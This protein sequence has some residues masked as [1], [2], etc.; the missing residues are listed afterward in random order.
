MMY[1]VLITRFLVK[2]PSYTSVISSFSFLFWVI[3]VAVLYCLV[4]FPFILFLFC[5]WIHNLT[6]AGSTKAKRLCSLQ[7]QDGCEKSRTFCEM[8]IY[9]FT[10]SIGDNQCHN[11]LKMFQMSSVHFVT[12][13]WDSVWKI[14]AHVTFWSLTWGMSF[15]AFIK[16]IYSPHLNL[17]S[18]EANI[19][20]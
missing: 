12:T 14:Q 19:L 11:I 2:T 9:I 18:L 15:Q 6:G 7:L 8:F 13:F 20:V 3:E 17:D 5:K 10:S 16:Y 1:S 4:G